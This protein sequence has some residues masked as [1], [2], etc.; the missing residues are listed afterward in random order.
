MDLSKKSF[1]TYQ[2]LSEEGNMVMNDI[3]NFQQKKKSKERQY[4]GER[5]KNLSEYE[6]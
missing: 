2:N 3:R 6:Q 5:Y 4:K 1:Q